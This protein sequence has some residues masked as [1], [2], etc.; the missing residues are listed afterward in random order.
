MHNRLI[1]FI[2][3][4]EILHHNQFGFRKNHSTSLAL[5]HLTNK[6]ASAIDREELTAGVFL[7]LSK[8]FDTLDHEIL[9]NKLERYGIYGMALLWIKSY[10]SNRKQFVQFRKTCSDEQVIKCGVPQGSVLGPLLF[11]L[12]INDLLNVSKVTESLLFADD[13]SIFHSHSNAIQLFSILNEELRKVDAWMKSNRLSVNIKKTNYVIFKSKQKRVNA[14]LSLYYN[15][16]PLKKEQ[17][18]KFLGVY[19][20]ENL[21]WIPYINHVCLKISKSIG[22]IYR[23][24]FYLSSKSKLALYYSL[25]YPYLSYCNITSAST[26]VTNLNRI[27]ILQKRAERVLTNSDFRAHSTPLF[28]QLKILDVFKLNAFHVAKFMFCHHH[29]ILPPLFSN[30]FFL[31]KQVHNY[32]TRSAD[33]YRSHNC[34]TN[35]KK[36]TVLFQGPSLRNSLPTYITNSETELCFRLLNY[37]LNHC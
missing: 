23:S 19:I 29:Q 6:I 18:T 8:A 11:I 10:L 9:F 25:V 31:N 13:T 34:R 17:F 15:N 30:L 16:N 33:D 32:H 20:D 4:F 12:Y 1:E 28:L 22:I 37:L 26:Y 27:F 3:R 35:T 14:N 5:A 21:S 24:R 7:D 2:E 36:F